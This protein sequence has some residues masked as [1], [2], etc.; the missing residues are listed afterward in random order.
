MVDTVLELCSTKW[1]AEMVPVSK[2][3][4]AALGGLPL[5]LAIAS[6]MAAALVLSGLVVATSL[7]QHWAQ[8]KL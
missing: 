6:S 3:T 5:N 4:I 7:A 2:P 1:G 8:A